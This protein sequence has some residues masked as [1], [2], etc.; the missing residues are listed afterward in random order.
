MS[1]SQLD[2]H[3]LTPPTQMLL[4]PQKDFRLH[5]FELLPKVRIQNDRRVLPQ[6][7]FGHVLSACPTPAEGA[8][9]WK[10]AHLALFKSFYDANRFGESTIQSK[11]R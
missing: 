10:P 4:Q 6:S 8:T 1:R 7:N 5:A 3:R 9:S 2:R 11:A